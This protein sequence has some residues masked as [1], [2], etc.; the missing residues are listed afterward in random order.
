MHG[1]IARWVER[2]MQA[3]RA[4]LGT[5]LLASIGLNFANVVARYGFAR[6]FEWAEE[7][8]TIILIWCVFL[9]AALVTWSDE[10]LRMT[11]I[12]ERLPLAWQRALRAAATACMVG[13]LGF[14]LYQSCRV[15]WFMA[16]MAQ[17]TAVTEM[18]SAIAHAAI[19]A[20]FALML[21]AILGR[22][23]GHARR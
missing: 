2:L 1:S 5:L 6:P 10:H 18:P 16:T 17:R 23:A 12:S 11:V 19:P 9:G 22:H 7:V 20:G 8:T 4:L 15:V 14:L 21:L 3:A 13:S